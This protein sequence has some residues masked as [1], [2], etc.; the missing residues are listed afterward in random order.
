MAKKKTPSAGDFPGEALGI[1]ETRGMIGA[2]EASDAMLK[3]ANV[4]F[5]GFQ[6]LQAGIVTVMVR[7]DVGAVQVAAEA[8]AEAARKVGELLGS[9][10]IPRPHELLEPKLP[11]EAD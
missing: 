8:G 7:G 3:S 1:V 5:A 9:H 10:T 11:A 6:K 4:H 2:I